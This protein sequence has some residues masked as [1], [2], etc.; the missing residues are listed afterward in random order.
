M[1]KKNLDYCFFS[2]Q[3]NQLHLVS[4][5]SHAQVGL[6]LFQ[7]FEERADVSSYVILAAKENLQPVNMSFHERTHLLSAFMNIRLH[8]DFTKLKRLESIRQLIDIIA[9]ICGLLAT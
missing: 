6:R 8:K 3:I 4:A 9:A 7:G 5:S 1:V 2:C